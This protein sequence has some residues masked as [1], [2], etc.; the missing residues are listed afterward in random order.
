MQSN[1]RKAAKAGSWYESDP[2]KLNDQLTSYLKKAEI[3]VPRGKKL[4]AIIG[5]HAGYEYS[6]SNAAWAYKNITCP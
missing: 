3:T 1:I 2:K 5:P 6:G 4:S